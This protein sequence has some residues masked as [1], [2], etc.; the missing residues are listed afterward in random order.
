MYVSS[1]DATANLMPGTSQEQ[2]CNKNTD[3]WQTLISCT[4]SAKT[5][6]QNQHCHQDVKP[7]WY[8]LVQLFFWKR[9]SKT[10]M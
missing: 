1:K 2:D 4:R 5:L 7:F 9:R 10:S 6:R 3:K 8:S